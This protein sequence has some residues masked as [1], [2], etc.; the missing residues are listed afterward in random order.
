[1]LRYPFITFTPSARNDSERAGN[2]SEW[3]AMA[4]EGLTV[5]EGSQW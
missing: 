2:D 1:M 4:E 3:V 5:E